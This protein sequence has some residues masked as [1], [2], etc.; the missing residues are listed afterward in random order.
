MM[1]NIF[2]LFG[3]DDHDLFGISSSSDG[4]DKE[5]QNQDKEDK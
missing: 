5:N 2:E 1:I 4:S 3:G